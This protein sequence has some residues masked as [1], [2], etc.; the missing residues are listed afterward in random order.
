MNG[1]GSHLENPQP[2]TLGPAASQTFINQLNTVQLSS[3]QAKNNGMTQ[4]VITAFTSFVR[5]KLIS[6]QILCSSFNVTFNS[7]IYEPI[8]VKHVTL[9]L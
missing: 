4:N 6:F 3:I 1:R 2:I 8:H 7:G 5:K 9:I